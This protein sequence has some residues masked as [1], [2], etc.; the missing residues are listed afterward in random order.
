MEE[1]VLEK[2]V[3]NW[4]QREDVENDEDIAECARSAVMVDGEL[5]NRVDI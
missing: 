1:R 4:G 5:S 2:N 3:G